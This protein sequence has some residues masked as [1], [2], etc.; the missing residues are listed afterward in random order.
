MDSAHLKL[1]GATMAPV[2]AS[3]SYPARSSA[4]RISSTRS[5]SEPIPASSHDW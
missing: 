3:L 4:L 1:D 2:S 5:G